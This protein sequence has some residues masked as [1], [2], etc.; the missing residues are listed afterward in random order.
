MKGFSE[1][2]RATIG[3]I[4]LSL[5]VLDLALFKSGVIGLGA[6]AYFLFDYIGYRREA[7]LNYQASR[8]LREGMTLSEI[9]A[10]ERKY[11]LRDDFN[12]FDKHAE[13]RTPLD[14]YFYY[15]KYE[16]VRDLVDLYGPKAGTWLDAGCGFGEDTLY[17]A[18][19]GKGKIVGL[20]LDEM[21]LSEA[22]R[23]FQ[24]EIPVSHM[25]LCG[26]DILH[27][28]FRPGTFDAILMTEVLEHL[29]NPKE[30]IQ[31]CQ[32]LLRDGGML[33]VSTP[34]LHNLDYSVNPFRILEKVLSLIDDR[35]LPPYHG[36][37]AQFEYNREKP[38]PEYG[39]HYHFSQRQ[40]GEMMTQHQF[41]ILWEGSFEIEVIPYRY[42]EKILSGKIDKIRKVVQPIEATLERIPVLNRLGQHL[43]LVAR[44]IPVEFGKSARRMN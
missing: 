9:R 16:R 18:N 6:L 17:L 4:S 43:L 21:K 25:L 31:I 29:V 11:L 37:H 14:R 26:G 7:M 2:T 40:L 33:I 13:V 22:S 10:I 28:P 23:K 39:I 36:L 15:A 5:L 35:I 1:L 38:E 19:R 30:G 34:S 8:T 24:K 20:E 12:T 41:E 27:P 3:L 44:K 42:V 32:S